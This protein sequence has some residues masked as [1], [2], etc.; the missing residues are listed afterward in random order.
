MHLIPQRATIEGSVCRAVE[1]GKWRL[2]EF[3]ENG[4]AKAN[5]YSNLNVQAQD[6]GSLRLSAKSGNT[7]TV[8]VQRGAGGTCTHG[9]VASTK[10][11]CEATVETERAI[12][13]LFGALDHVVLEGE[14]LVLSGGQYRAVFTRA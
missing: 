11:Y 12:S 7:I 10:M 3:R 2:H 14:N 9:Q 8:V 1:E 5:I 6:D 4:Q 13:A